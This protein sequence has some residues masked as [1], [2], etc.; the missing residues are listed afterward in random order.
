M[1]L[2]TKSPA[3]L[4]DPNG[5]IAPQIA[6][7]LRTQIIRNALP[8][9]HRLSEAEI[10][11]AAGVS[12][13]PVREAFIKLAEQGLVQVLPQRGTV[14]SKIDYGAVL[15]AR[16]LRE[17]IEADICAILAHRPDRGLIRSL[18]TQLLR[19]RE[20]I[21]GP[22]EAFTQ[23]DERFHRTLAEGAGKESA[24]RLLEGLKSQ[25]DRVRFLALGHAP[26]AALVDQHAL[27]V[28]AIEA[29]E[30]PAVRRAIR[31]HLRSVLRDLPDIRAANPH[32]FDLPPE[33][34]QDPTHVPDL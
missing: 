27:V 4:L 5:R 1:T 6:A 31:G 17:A 15:D 26:V 20:A 12:R 10:A 24:W 22:P 16:F 30:V 18:R 28:D 29:G 7:H 3:L 13:Q 34:L 19:Q 14:V 32:V 9:G 11:R 8:P 2:P 21:D 25:M 23:L 33:G